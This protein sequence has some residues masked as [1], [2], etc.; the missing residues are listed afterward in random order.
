MLY[1]IIVLSVFGLMSCA[2]PVPPTGGPRDQQPPVIEEVRPETGTIQFTGKDFDIVFDEYINRGSVPNA[3][4][5]EPALGLDYSLDWKRTRLRISFEEDLPDSTTVIITLG[6]EVSDINGNDLGSSFSLAVSTGDR[7]DSGELTGKVLSANDGKPLEQNVILLFREPY[8]MGE[9]AAYRAQTDTSGRFRFSYLK[10]GRY[11]AIRVDDRNRNNAWDQASEQAQPF[12]EEFIQ[13]RQD[14]SDTLQ[15]MYVIRRDTTRPSLLGV[16]LLSSQR[17][18]LRFDEEPNTRPDYSISITDSAGAAY[19]DAWL[20]Y[21]SAQDPLVI[22]A[23][24]EK[25]LSADKSYGIDLKGFEDN[26]GNT[27]KDNKILFEGSAQED[28]TLQRLVGINN[29]KIGYRDSIVITFASSI[30][31]PEVVDSTVVIEGDVAF[32]DWPEIY[33]R[34]NKL[35]IGPQEQWVGAVNYQFQVWDPAQRKRE[36]FR[37]EIWDSTDYGAIELILEE[38]DS[39]SIYEVILESEDATISREY[40]LNDRLLIPDLPPVAYR[41]TVYLDKNGNGQWDEGSVLPFQ[42]P[43]PYFVQSPVRIEDG[44]TSTIRLNFN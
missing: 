20:L 22:F 1:H 43:E 19:S 36:S 12:N 7:I 18:R 27:L 2:N 6:S 16:G 15:T 33:T 3:I 29:R 34:K 5:V 24:S 30:T 35:I 32:D 17:L 4:T 10:E 13:I 21:P 8:E 42:A 25:A 38:A 37:P 26:S 39:L 40:T 23:Q 41:L 44:F 14:T 11:K 9:R 31:E 28:T